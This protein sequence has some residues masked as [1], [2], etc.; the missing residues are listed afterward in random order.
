MQVAPADLCVPIRRPDVGMPQHLLNDPQ[1]GA[2]LEQMSRKRVTQRVGRDPLGNAS[3][4][5]VRLDPRP[6][7]IPI[8]PL[9]LLR[10]KERLFPPRLLPPLRQVEVNC[11]DGHRGNRHNPILSPLPTHPDRLLPHVADVETT[12][13][14]NPKP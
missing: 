9:P 3:V 12:Q 1:V 11:C 7:E 10:D 2:V 6:N 4:S 5:G 8:N 14:G 13:L